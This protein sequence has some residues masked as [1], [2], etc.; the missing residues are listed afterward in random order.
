MARLVIDNRR[1]ALA[2]LDRAWSN[3]VAEFYAGPF[4]GSLNDTPASELP[5]SLV[6]KTLQVY[7]SP[8]T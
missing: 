6:F 8:Q 7:F 1:K 2:D 4:S 5:S 3:I